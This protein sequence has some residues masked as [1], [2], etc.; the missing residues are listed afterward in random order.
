M[1]Q[2]TNEF[3]RRVKIKTRVVATRTEL[4]QIHR[5]EQKQPPIE[6][7]LQAHERTQRGGPVA[8]LLG[9]MQLGRDRFAGEQ[10]APK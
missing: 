2:A 3:A 10:I 1:Q 8:Q 4:T 7:T 5:R 9:A 6:D